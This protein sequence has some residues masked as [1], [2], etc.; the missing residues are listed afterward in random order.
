[1]FETSFAWVSPSPISPHTPLSGAPRF[2]GCAHHGEPRPGAPSGSRGLTGLTTLV[3]RRKQSAPFQARTSRKCDVANPHSAR[4]PNSPTL[5]VGVC[6]ALS[7]VRQTSDTS[8]TLTP[9]SASLGPRRDLQPILLPFSVIGLDV[10]APE[11]SARRT[12]RCDFG[13]LRGFTGG[14]VA[15]R[16]GHGNGRGV[17]RV[18][19]LPCDEQP[20]AQA[21]GTDPLSTGRDSAMRVRTSAAARAMALLPRRSR[22]LP[23]DIACAPGFEPHNA[24]RLELQ[25]KRLAELQAAHGYVSHGVGAMLN[26]AAWLYAGGEFAAEL[27]AETGNVE[28]FKVA[29]NL[30]STARQH[31]LAAWELCSREARAKSEEADDWVSEMCP[32]PKGNGK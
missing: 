15:L 31:E 26:A 27:G 18:E 23:R 17:P 9:C 3:E 2:G 8:R 30:T 19:V 20:L 25:R 10:S 28:Y 1:M 5:H 14:D 7:S 32:K 16:N 22:Y 24:R 12:Q 13:H 11:V 29:S 4:L 21:A 6:P